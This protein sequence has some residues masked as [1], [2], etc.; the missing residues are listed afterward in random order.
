MHA[1]LLV[2]S[3][4]SRTLLA[5][6][7]ATLLLAGCSGSPTAPTETAPG[8]FLRLTSAPGDFIGLGISRYY[9]VANA[10]FRPVMDLDRRHLTVD[11]VT[12]DHA[13]DWT[14]NATAPEGQQL[15]RR[16]YDRAQRWPF[17]FPT[18]AGFDFSGSGRGCS[19]LEARFVIREL[20]YGRLGEVEKLDMI[21][22]QQCD[23]SPDAL[24]GE[25][26]IVDAGSR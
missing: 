14:L 21:F 13:E 15:T 26:V 24:T 12:L 16:T 4:F 18:V 8:S 2:E 9:T 7:V 5:T 3:G 19:R 6:V 1:S 17:A 22:E 25:L 23:G 11:V 20:T 10:R